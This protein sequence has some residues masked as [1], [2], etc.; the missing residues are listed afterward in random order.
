MTDTRQAPPPRSI[1]HRA[2]VP[3]AIDRQVDMIVVDGSSS[4]FDKWWDMMDAIDTYVGSVK[5]KAIQSYVI[6]TT[7][8]TT[9]INCIQ[10]NTKI[11][12]WVPI[13]QDP[14]GSHG[15]T[16]PL[17]DAINTM[18]RTMRQMD[19][20]RASITIVTDGEENASKTSL[21]QARAILDWCRAK[22]WQITFIGC[23]FDNSHQ[24]AALGS[25][26][27]AFIG[28]RKQKL[29]EAMDSLAEKRQRYSSTGEDMHF[30]DEEKIKF[31][32]YLAG[33]SSN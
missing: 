10:R 17:Y 21:A 4:M 20:K 16:T 22:G 7:F 3:T 24:A 13:H 33:P 27:Q 31:G 8:D 23:D 19:P 29:R 2:D 25:K 26:P 30:T 15:G 6:L 9:D 5:S 12:D 18:G 1:V 28:V 11:E 32:G 14:I